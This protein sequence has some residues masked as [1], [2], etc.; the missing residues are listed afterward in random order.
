MPL[1][2]VENIYIYAG[3]LAATC[4]TQFS[5]LQLRSLQRLYSIFLPLTFLKPD[6]YLSF[7]SSCQFIA[8]K[9]PTVSRLLN[10][11]VNIV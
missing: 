8:Q 1:L 9:R 2:D 7:M 11:P 4:L 6:I 10:Q 3:A 5:K